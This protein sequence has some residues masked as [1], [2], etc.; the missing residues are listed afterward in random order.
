MKGAGAKQRKQVR[1]LLAMTWYRRHLHEGVAAFC[2]ERRWAL[3]SLDY[4][5]DLENANLWDGIILLHQSVPALQ[6]FLKKGVPIIT[7]AMDEIGRLQTPAVCQDQEAI[8]T[9]GA[10]HLLERGFRRLLFCGYRDAIS[11]ARFLGLRAESE[12]QHASYREICLPHRTPTSEESDYILRWV[13]AHLLEEK[14]PFAVMAAH[15]L[16]GV[17]VIDASLNAGLKV[18]EQV[19]VL[20]VDNEEIICDCAQVPLSSVDNSLFLQGYE[21]AKLLFQILQGETPPAKPVMVPPRLVVI[22]ASTDTIAAQDARLAQ[23]LQH[24]HNQL[25]DTDVCVKGIC[26][27]FGLSR[28]SLGE[29]FS[30]ANLKPPGHV[31]HEVRLRRACVQLAEGPT[32]INEVAKRCGFSSARSFCRFFRKMKGSSPESWRQQAKA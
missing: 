8:G 27:R 31:I 13:A 16:L 32:P 23:I 26:A 22:R 12:Q 7:L 25:H 11:H 5:P 29:L 14:P 2:R 4:S 21:A 15:D 30:R 28:H 3:D 24:I 20:G 9:M 18:P 1:V 6:K 10:R 17:T 19:A